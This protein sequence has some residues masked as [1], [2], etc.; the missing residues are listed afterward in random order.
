MNRN[1]TAF[2]GITVIG[3]G[4]LLLA[5]CAG[6]PEGGG[7]APSTEQLPLVGYEDVAYDDLADGGTLSLAQTSSPTAEGSWNPQHA[8]AAN[9]DVQAILDPTLGATI[10]VNADGSWEANP[11]YAESVELTSED[12]QVITVV[13]NPDAVFSDG[14]ALTAEDYIATYTALAD[15]TGAY[16]IIPSSV[17]PAI[18]ETE[19]V[20]DYEFT[21]TFGETYADW[22]GMF[23]TSPLPSEIASD[24]AAFNTGYTSAPIPSVG[25]FVFDQVDNDA[26]I[27]TLVPNPEWWG[28]A[29]KLE[30]ISFTVIDQEALPQA[31]ANDEID[32]I[33]IQTPDALEIASGK[34]GAVI[35][36]SGGLTWSH[37]TFNGLAAPF[38]DVNVRLAVAKAV[39]RELISRVANE[40]LGVPAT[41]TGDWIFMPGQN[42]YTDTFGEAVGLDLEG[43][44]TLLEESGWT[45]TGEGDD[46]H[47]EKDG[48]TL[49]FSVVV[50]AGTESNINRALGVQDSLAKLNIEVTLEEVPGTDYF[51]VISEGEFQAVTFGWSGTLFPI[52][53]AEPV[54][55]PGQ[56][57][58]DQVGYNYSFI[59]DD[60]LGDLWDQA[61]AELDEDARI[62]IA[63]EINAVMAELM[64]VV[65]IYPYPEVVATDEGLSNFGTATFKGTDW[66]TVGYLP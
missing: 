47:W 45:L 18:T 39:D 38:D 3:V 65:P 26:Q 58:G 57:Y 46:A 1:A 6:T 33:E 62:E 14:S 52:S 31:F 56:E 44:A 25:P 54:F 53:A 17:F 24:P 21:V 9:V 29:P 32:Y 15:D 42:G 59:S 11:Y 23:L 50:P 61:N 66:T 5:G 10:K 27:Y 12:P 34:D 13:L 37:L 48:E 41:T 36:R 43:A 22:P 51:T 55:Y 60:R 8:G 40:P 49:E 4:A 16:E 20:S 2:T 28:P 63:K 35:Q 64:S 30:G 19:I 7:D